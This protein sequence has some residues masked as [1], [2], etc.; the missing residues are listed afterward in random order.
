MSVNRFQFSG[1]LTRDVELATT[2]GDRARARMRL[3][4]NDAWTD[5]QGQRQERANYFSITVWGRDAENAA[6]YLGKG[7][8]IFVEGRIESTEWEKDGEKRYGNDFVAT[9]IDYIDTRKPEA[10]TD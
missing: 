10:V 1:N 3:A 7:S 8:L 9:Q 2:T 4:V 6:K 5:S